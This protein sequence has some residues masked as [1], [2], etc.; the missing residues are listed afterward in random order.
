MNTEIAKVEHDEFELVL[1]TE[2]WGAGE[3]VAAEDLLIPKILLQQKM[4]DLVDQGKAKPGEFRSSLSGELLGDEKKPVEVI[5]FDAFKNWLIFES[6]QYAG[7]VPYTG[8]R[9]AYEE[10]TT[11][12]VL[13]YNFYCL[14]ASRMDDIP[15][16][17]SL[18]RTGTRAA[19]SLMT[20]FARLARIKKPSAAKTFKLSCHQEK[21]EKGSYHVCDVLEGRDT[22]AAEQ[23]AAHSWYQD[24]RKSR[25]KV[26]HDVPA[27]EGASVKDDALPF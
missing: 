27:E 7:N 25:V 12:R 3:G 9:L 23:S 6:D 15:H 13:C 19:K 14:L 17:L 11:K 26:V 5:F 2:S 21:N 18:S 8:E 1:P 24:I 16:L 10:G 20:A 22:T 4:S